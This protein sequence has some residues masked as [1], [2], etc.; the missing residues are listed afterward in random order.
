[1]WSKLFERPDKD[2]Y[3]VASNVKHRHMKQLEVKC[4]IGDGDSIV[5]SQK[6]PERM[7]VLMIDQDITFVSV[8]INKEQAKEIADYLNNWFEK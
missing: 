4:E 7:H 2:D 3:V 5:F 8:V 6:N 1:M